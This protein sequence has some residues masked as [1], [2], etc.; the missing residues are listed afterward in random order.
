MP[1]F[2]P[3]LLAGTG[4]EH[5]NAILGRPGP[6]AAPLRLAAPFA[7]DLGLVAQP[8]EWTARLAG[9][10][11]SIVRL[12]HVQMA[13]PA[14]ER[15]RRWRSTRDC[16]ASRTWLSRCTLRRGAAAGSSGATSRRISAWT[17]S[18]EGPPKR[19]PASIVDGV[20][21]LGVAAGRRRPPGR[22][23]RI[24]GRVR[25][26]LRRRSVRQPDRVQGVATPAA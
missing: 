6:T 14:D 25:P 26:R 9:L 3:W 16:S 12:D 8:P 7:L 17:V 24:A 23:G 15:P 22:G 2:L 20:R 11:T 10:D 1:Q 18:S 19:T 13:M 21:E 5:T 4:A